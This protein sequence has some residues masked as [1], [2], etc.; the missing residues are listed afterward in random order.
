M[1]ESIIDL[2]WRLRKTGTGGEEV[3]KDT[4]E[5]AKAAREA[6]K[7]AREASKIMEENSKKAKDFAIGLG[8][9]AVQGLVAFGAASLKAAS[10]AAEMG[11]KFD[12]VFKDQ[13]PAAKQALEQLADTINRSKF[14]LMG[15]AATLQDT[16]VPLGF[17]RDKA[18]EMS[19]SVVAL[20]E[21]LASF[22][23]LRTEDVV[24]DL[25]S[26]L[27]GNTETLRKYGVVAQDAQIK[28]KG[29]EMGLWDGTS[30]MDGQTKAAIILQLAI[31]GTSDAQGDA[32][33]TAAGFANQMKGAEAAVKELQIEVGNKMLPT[34]IKFVGIMS[35]GIGVLT[36][37]V[38]WTDRVK[39]ALNDHAGAVIETSDGYAAYVAELTRATEST[40]YHV[41]ANGDLVDAYGR[42]HQAG[43]ILT[44]TE[45]GLAQAELAAAAAA[46]ESATATDTTAAALTYQIQTLGYGTSAYTTHTAAVQADKAAAEAAAAAADTQTRIYGLAADALAAA[47]IP[48]FQKVE[49]E[50]Q[51]ALA[52]GATTVEQEKE[53]DAIALLR[54]QMELGNVDGAKFNEIV[55]LMASGAITAQQAIDMVTASINAIPKDTQVGITYNLNTNGSPPSAA[56]GD[57]GIGPAGSASTA[58]STATGGTVAYGGAQAEGGAYTVTQPTWFLAGEAG[59][60]MAYFV[61][62]GK[63][64]SDVAGG[65]ALGNITININGAQSPMETARAVRAELDRMGRRADSRI[66]T[67]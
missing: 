26:A 2:I 67:N 10:D 30:A 56:A 53:K 16:F 1:S 37:L 59:T 36:D 8:K 18:A 35:D 27:V 29:L 49:L 50:K 12:T 9:T 15:Y 20:A 3:V 4:K 17:A 58:Y 38:T 63:S 55:G 48:L 22:N 61:P 19:V 39:G 44:E 43:Y 34:A 64:L 41:N 66:R 57:V 60:E 5:A 54:R 25:Q 52:S 31:E 51:L 6:A 21:D 24:N 32:E 33:R 42:V 47:N 40:S 28:A 46:A 7:A 23:N 13:G 11:S 62:Q 65:G 14:D 45:Y